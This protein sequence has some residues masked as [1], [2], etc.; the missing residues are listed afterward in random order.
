MK[1]LLD[2]H[3]W[4]WQSLDLAERGR[5]T[6][7]TS[8]AEWVQP[9]GEAVPRREAPLTHDIAVMSRRLALSALSR[10]YAVMANK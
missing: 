9:M 10:E 4:V 3:I 6:V 8:L 2:T 7:R 5:V 1:L